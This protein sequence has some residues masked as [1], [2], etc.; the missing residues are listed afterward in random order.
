MWHEQDRR[1]VHEGFW[2][3]TLKKKEKI[4]KINRLE[5]LGKDGRI[6]RHILRE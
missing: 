4:R 5:N 3:K 1:K 6:L 2:W